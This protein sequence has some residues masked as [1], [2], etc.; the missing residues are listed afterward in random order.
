MAAKFVAFALG[1]RPRS[2]GFQPPNGGAAGGTRPRSLRSR[3]AAGSRRYDSLAGREALWWVWPG[4]ERRRFLFASADPP[5][6][7]GWVRGGLFTLLGAGLFL[8]GGI[9][10]VRGELLIGGL[11][12]VPG[13]VFGLHFGAFHLLALTL[14]ARGIDAVPLMDRP[15]SSATLAEFWGR[16][17][18]TAFAFLTREALFA[19]LSRRLGVGGALWAGFLVSGLIHEAALTLPVRTGYGGPTLYFLLQAAGVTTERRLRSVGWWSPAVGRAFAA[20]VLIAPLPLLV[21]RAFLTEAAGPLAA[22]VAS[23]FVPGSTGG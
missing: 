8:A 18:N 17:W 5:P 20:A 10:T 4:L 9:L 1:P 22:G 6:R 16:R 2:G 3:T 12:A 11:C 7:A 15:L 23:W 14:R 21:P 19:P 13:F